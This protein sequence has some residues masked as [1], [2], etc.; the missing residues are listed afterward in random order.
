MIPGSLLK[1]RDMFKIHKKVKY[2]LVALKGIKARPVRSLVT[3]KE[4]CEDF[5][6]P[7]D[8]TSRV[9]QLMAQQG[10]LEAVQGAHGGYR[11]TGNLNKV[12][13]QELSETVMGPV[14]VTDCTT[15]ENHP[16]ERMDKCV[17]KAGMAKLNS[18]LVRV[19]KDTKISEI[20]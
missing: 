3:A 9:L 6:I 17:L 16:C 14:A 5:D 4:I 18:R 19:F 1:W 10:L 20:V 8:P 15:G 7:F 13:L 12:S 11:L 2:A